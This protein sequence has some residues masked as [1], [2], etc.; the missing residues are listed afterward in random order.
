MI[1]AA[2]AAIAALD[3]KARVTVLEGDVCDMDLGLAGGEYRALADEVTAIHHLASVY[4]HGV[5][6]EAAER[7]N[8]EGTR[9]ML[10]LAAECRRLRRFTHFSTAQVSGD[11][12]G[13]V[14]EEELDCGQRFGS[15]YEET[16][17]RA[18]RLVQAAARRLP[19]TVLRPGIIVGDS[20]SGEIDRFDG[21]YYL[22]VLIVTSPLDVHLPLPGRVAPL[23]P[24]AAGMRAVA[25][26]VIERVSCA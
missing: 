13:V 25:Q 15:V 11:R 21:P 26:M 17:F 12:S 23:H 2:L 20:K 19:V 7:V 9:A 14:L 8:V 16:K 5:P 1:K 10:D 22:T 3:A 18:E 6:R 4:Y 24:N